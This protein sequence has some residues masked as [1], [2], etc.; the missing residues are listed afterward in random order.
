[1]VYLIVQ[2]ELRDFVI[3]FELAEM[4]AALTVSITA[5]VAR[6]SSRYYYSRHFHPAKMKKKSCDYLLGLGAFQPSR[7]ESHPPHYLKMHYAFRRAN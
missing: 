2:T 1:M 5:L 3:H 7:K 6:P 4:A